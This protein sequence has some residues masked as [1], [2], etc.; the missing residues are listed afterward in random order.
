MRVAILTVSDA[1]ARGERA[2]TSGDAIEAW[3][4]A[5]G[6]IVA[7]RSIVPDDTVEIVRQLITWCDSDAADLVLTTGGTGLSPRDHTPEATRAA[8]EREAPALAERMRLLELERFPRAAL[9]RAVAGIRHRT[10][11]INLPGSPSGC[12]THSP[13][14][15]PSSIMRSTLCAAHPR[16]TRLRSHEGTDYADGR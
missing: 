6:A 2:D 16:T 14:S 5:R 9:T 12:E 3:T 13:P 1:G 8:I 7:G 4:I 15:T 10:L 11:I